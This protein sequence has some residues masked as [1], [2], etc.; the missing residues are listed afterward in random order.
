MIFNEVIRQVGGGGGQ[1]YSEQPNS[2]GGNTAI[3]T[4]GLEMFT[5]GAFNKAVYNNTTL[6]DL[7]SDTVTPDDVT[8]GLTFHDSDGI[9]QT[10]TYG[11]RYVTSAIASS[12]SRT[13]TFTGLLY[14]PSMFYIHQM[15]SPHA[16]GYNPDSISTSTSNNLIALAVFTEDSAYMLSTKQSSSGNIT[17]TYYDENN[18]SWSYSSGELT[19]S[20]PSNTVG[21][22]SSGYYF[23]YYI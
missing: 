23:L 3:I 5:G 10:G 15:I 19:I 14:E 16:T 18:I 21:Q 2:A 1:T 22:F 11:V 9:Q 4:G 20:S 12:T 7:S 17:V 8:A 13:K 6:I